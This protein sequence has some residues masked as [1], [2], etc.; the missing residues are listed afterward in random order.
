M[1]KH[2][3]RKAL[4]HVTSNVVGALLRLCLV[5]AG[6]QGI[7]KMEGSSFAS[8]LPRLVLALSLRAAKQSAIQA[9]SPLTSKDEIPNF[10]F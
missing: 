4:S 1:I 7:V 6:R 3:R 2:M 9:P 10:A 5:T 8:A